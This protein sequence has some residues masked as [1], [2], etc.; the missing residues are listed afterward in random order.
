MC[1]CEIYICVCMY[2]YI[3]IYICFYEYIMTVEKLTPTVYIFFHKQQSH[4]SCTHKE[5]NLHDKRERGRERVR[6]SVRESD[7]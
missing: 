2:T 5:C 4:L 3:Y 6:E 7:L 1:V